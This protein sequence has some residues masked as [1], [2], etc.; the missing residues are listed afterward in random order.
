MKGVPLTPS[1]MPPARTGTLTPAT[2]VIPDAQVYQASQDFVENTITLENFGAFDKVI[3]VYDQKCNEC[4]YS[5]LFVPAHG[6]VNVALCGDSF[7]G[8]SSFVID[9]VNAETG[10][11]LGQTVYSLVSDGEKKTF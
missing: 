11:P 5:T 10:N 4:A 3:S 1:V 2:P 7:T 9:K 8:Y 6:Q